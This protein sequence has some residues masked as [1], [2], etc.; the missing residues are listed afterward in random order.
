M[1]LNQ[2][3]NVEPCMQVS[4]SVTEW[5]DVTCMVYGGGV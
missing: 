3:V 2:G 1:T 4:T 5:P